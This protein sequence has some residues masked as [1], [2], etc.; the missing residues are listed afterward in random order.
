MTRSSDFG[1][2]AERELQSM[3]RLP[4][5]QNS[6]AAHI[7]PRIA[8]MQ[9]MLPPMIPSPS[10]LTMSNG[11]QAPPRAIHALQP[12][13]GLSRTQPTV[14]SPVGCG[15]PE[16]APRPARA[17]HLSPLS[18]RRRPRS[19]PVSWI[20]LRLRGAGSK[21]APQLVENGQ[22]L[23]HTPASSSTLAFGM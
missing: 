6:P 5:G 10:N 13:L 1:D 11:T 2:S 15:R 23:T 17:L 7:D 14:T 12:T 20:A 18:S 3:P 22:Q 8:L 21:R 4:L 16:A 19:L 9:V